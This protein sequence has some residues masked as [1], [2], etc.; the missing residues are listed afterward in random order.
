MP[1]FDQVTVS[2]NPNQNPPEGVGFL[3][4]HTNL[5]YVEV[6][7]QLYAFYIGLFAQAGEEDGLAGVIGQ[8]PTG[9]IGSGTSFNTVEGQAIGVLGVRNPENAVL[10]DAN[11]AGVAGFSPLAFNYPNGTHDVPELPVFNMGVYGQ[12]K[13]STG[14]DRTVVGIGVYGEGETHGLCGQVGSVVPTIL[15]SSWT[16]GVAGFGDP[17]SSSPGVLGAGRGPSAY[18]VT[19]ISTFEGGSGGGV[20][21]EGF[22]IGVSAKPRS[23][24]Q[25]ALLLSVAT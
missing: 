10:D 18:G 12:G 19:G 5:D 1:T 9:V 25:I 21:G 14:T 6:G 8:G 24:G 22:N 20:F 11:G 15:P 7:G 3:I 17:K 2:P 23:T 13:T 4:D 16:A